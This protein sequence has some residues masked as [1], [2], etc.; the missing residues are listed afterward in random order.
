M[1]RRRHHRPQHVGEPV[2]RQ[3]RQTNFVELLDGI[4]LDTGLPPSQLTLEITEA[5]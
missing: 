5:C 1:D 2:R 3:L 4:L